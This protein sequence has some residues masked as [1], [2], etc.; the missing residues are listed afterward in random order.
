[1]FALFPMLTVFCPVWRPAVCWV[2]GRSF[3]MVQICPQA[4]TGRFLPSSLLGYVPGWEAARCSVV[5]MGSIIFYLFW[6]VAA[7][8][9]WAV[10][11][12][13]SW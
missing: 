2:T 7:P 1:M 4:G 13:S 6:E 5:P 9:S 11:D 12:G 10:E 3:G 8:K